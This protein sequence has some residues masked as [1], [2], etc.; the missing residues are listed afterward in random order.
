MTAYAPDD[1][2]EGWEFK[3]L[4]SSTGAFKHPHV[5]Q[6]AI[7]EE[8][9]AGWVLVEKFDNQRLRFKRPASARAG[10]ATLRES[11]GGGRGGGGGD[12]DAYRTTFGISEGRLALTIVATIIGVIAAIM[13][14]I[15]FLV[16]R[17]A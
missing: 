9:R 1:L 4:R 6:Q 17:L 15:F 10:D 2:A 14:L 3:I 12:F 11:G 16:N 13:G 8:G 7:Q 5:L